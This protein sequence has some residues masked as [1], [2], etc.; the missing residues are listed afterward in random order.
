VDWEAVQKNLESYRITQIFLLGF[1][2]LLPASFL[3][4]WQG[5][6]WNVHPSLLPAYPGLHSIERALADGNPIGVTIH[7]V[8]P[9]MDAGPIRL[10]KSLGI[11]PAGI[12][13]EHARLEVAK[14][15]QSLI[16]NW[17]KRVEEARS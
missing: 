9:E 17:V 11:L 10:Q 15:E 6:I 1:M 8:V 16:Q 5:R 14:L 7:D 3:D 12:P 4:P 13:F 2:K